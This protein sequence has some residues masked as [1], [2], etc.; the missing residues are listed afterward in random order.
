MT[1]SSTI[2]GDTPQCYY[3]LDELSGSVANDSSGNSH[4]AKVSGASYS[5]PGALTSD[6][7][8]CMYFTAAGGLTLPSTLNPHSWS[9]A[10][11]EFWVNVGSG[12]HYI[13]ITTNA[14]ATILYLDTVVTT[15]GTG[16]SIQTNILDLAGS[17]ISS[18]Y[19]DEVAL[20]NYVLT[21]T[22]I[23]AHYAA[24]SSGGGGSPMSTA[25]GTRILGM[26]RLGDGQA[27]LIFPRSSALP[28][29]YTVT[30][31]KYGVPIAITYIVERRNVAPLLIY[32]QIAPPTQFA[33]N[34]NGNIIKPDQVTYTLRPVANRTLLGGPL[35]QG[36]PSVTWNYAVLQ[37]DEFDLL[38]SLYNPQA[39]LVTLTYPDETG[40]WRQVQAV[41]Q[42]P[43]Y[44]TRQTVV[45]YNVSF[46]FL[47]SFT[48]NM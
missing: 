46:S 20:Y 44:G 47:L 17:L 2:L 28:V 22:K 18:G 37:I 45:V 14:T 34:G 35:L 29:T 43:T 33:I 23:T 6:T 15:S 48:P 38:V 21:P 40:T 24:S 5:K 11:L 9:A 10:S 4:T 8:T 1:Y 30:L 25:L 13:V 7:D 26:A 31:S 19:L 36:I 16:A 42:P 12:W 32:Y 41:M 3:R 27:L 39:P